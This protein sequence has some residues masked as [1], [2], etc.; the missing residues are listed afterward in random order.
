M[1]WSNA[2]HASAAAL[3]AANATRCTLIVLKI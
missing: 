2:D 1:T 3:I